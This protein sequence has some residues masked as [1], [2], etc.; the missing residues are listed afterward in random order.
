MTRAFAIRLLITALVLGAIAVVE[1]RVTGLW[2]DSR[3]PI[4]V[5]QS[6]T[7]QFLAQ[8]L[9]DLPMPPPLHDGDVLIPQDMTPAARAAAIFG[10]ALPAGST[11]DFSV[12]RDGH[13]LHV[14]VAARSAPLSALNRLGRWLNGLFVVPLLSAL[15]LLTLWRGRGRASGGLCA[16]ATFALL[17]TAL[18]AAVAVPL[19]GCWLNSIVY[20]AQYLVGIPALYVMAEALADTGLSLRARRTARLAIAGLVAAGAGISSVVTIGFVYWDITLPYVVGTMLLAISGLSVALVLVVLFF[21]YRRAGH[22]S[23]LRIRWVLWSTAIFLLIVVGLLGISQTRHPY[24]FQ[25]IASAQWLA[26][27]GYFYAAFRNRLVDVSFV[28]NRALVYA[29]LTALLFGAFSLLELGLH[30]LAVGEKLSWALQAGA[31]LLFAIAL[32]PVHRR[33][34]NRIERLFF[35]KQRLAISAIRDFATECA[36]VEQEGR[37]LQIAVERLVPH[38]E[39]VAVYERS[40]SGYLLRASRGRASPDTIDVDDPA[41]VSLR[42]RRRE[43]DLRELGSAAGNDGLALPMAVGERLTGAVICH[44]RAAEQFAPDVRAA[45]AEAARNLGMSLYLLRFR[46]QERLVADI[47]AGHIDLIGARD[48][49]T[50]LVPGAV[51]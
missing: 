50:A 45:L 44:P 43:I 38:C 19:V 30:Q 8:P 47:A 16:F 15:V 36:F 39:G 42:A 18:N 14:A 9:G 40:P 2:P 23:R 10:P 28:V 29:T 26:L 17:G 35:R 27:L 22:E 34:E 24:L 20:V 51:V 32:S 25:V 12:L 49:A 5:V 21:G 41:F 33:I 48:R 3:I 6:S 1:V 4:N 46:E 11:F 13:V 7:G 31:A 37:L